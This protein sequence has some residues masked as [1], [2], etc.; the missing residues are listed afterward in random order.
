[1]FIILL[2]NANYEI[3]S[4]GDPL[5]SCDLSDVS[6]SGLT[7]SDKQGVSLSLYILLIS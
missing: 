3:T 6:V 2:I 4:E 7:E 5:F 1:M